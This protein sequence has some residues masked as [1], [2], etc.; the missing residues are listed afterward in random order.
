MIGDIYEALKTHWDGIGL[1]VE[2]YQAFPL[3]KTTTF[4]IVRQVPG[5]QTVNRSTCST[6]DMFLFEFVVY[7]CR[8]F[9]QCDGIITSVVDAFENAALTLTGLVEC[10]R[11]RPPFI[12]Q[13]EKTSWVGSFVLAV[14]VE[15]SF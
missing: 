10:V 4:G 15:R 14:T 12:E 8:T 6:T 13:T 11:Q 9:E 7:H 1:G 5:G 2:L 3:N